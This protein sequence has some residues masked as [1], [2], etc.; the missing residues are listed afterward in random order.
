MSAPGGSWGGSGGGELWERPQNH[1]APGQRDQESVQGDLKI[2]NTH[3][4]M[5]H[6]LQREMATIFSAKNIL[7]F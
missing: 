2:L 3:D 7:F 4:N 5:S 1:A 6:F